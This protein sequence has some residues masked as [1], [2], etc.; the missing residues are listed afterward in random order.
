MGLPA[1][2]QCS[3]LGS[4]DI[5]SYHIQFADKIYCFAEY[6]RDL[7]QQVKHQTQMYRQK[8]DYNR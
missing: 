5:T 8:T 4:P 7:L 3:L 2:I 6:E 1:S